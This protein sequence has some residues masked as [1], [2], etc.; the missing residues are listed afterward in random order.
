MLFFPMQTLDVSDEGVLNSALYKTLQNQF[1]LLFAEAQHVS[2]SLYLL[3]TIYFHLYTGYVKRTHRI[4]KI[5]YLCSPTTTHKCCRVLKLELVH[6]LSSTSRVQKC[7][8]RKENYFGG[9]T[10]SASRSE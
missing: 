6:L 5:F 10:Y 1:T 2:S 4:P 9:L 8:R 3:F 7:D